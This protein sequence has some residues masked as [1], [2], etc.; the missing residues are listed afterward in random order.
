MK[1]IILS[2]FITLF[3]LGC[4][5]KVQTNKIPDDKKYNF[6]MEYETNLDITTTLNKE[7]AKYND[8]AKDFFK[9]EQ[10]KEINKSIYHIGMQKGYFNEK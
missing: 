1:T 6:P 7:K 2:I 10:R 8:Y 3:F 4:S 9:V 5:G